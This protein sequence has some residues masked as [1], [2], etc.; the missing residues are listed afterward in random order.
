MNLVVTEMLCL[1]VIICGFL[2][3]NHFYGWT[4]RLA[5]WMRSTPSL[6]LCVYCK[7]VGHFS[8]EA[9]QEQDLWHEGAEEVPCQDCNL[10]YLRIPKKENRNEN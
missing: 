6:A 7:G 8:V 2:Q 10:H 4:K 5:K 3:C 9:L 1:A